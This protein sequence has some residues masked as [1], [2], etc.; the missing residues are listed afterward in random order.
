[1]STNAARHLRPSSGQRK[2]GIFIPSKLA[3]G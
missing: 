2:G 3:G 1:M